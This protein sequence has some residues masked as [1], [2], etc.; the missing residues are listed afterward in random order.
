MG[1]SASKHPL[2]GN[3]E[4]GREL[5]DPVVVERIDGDD[6][7]SGHEVERHVHRLLDE[8]HG[9]TGGGDLAH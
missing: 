6:T 3:P 8:D 9:H 2:M 1:V 4:R 5:G 7:A